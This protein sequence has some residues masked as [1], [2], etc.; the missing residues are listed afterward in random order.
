MAL[1]TQEPILFAKTIADNIAYGDNSRDIPME[2]IIDAAK[3]ANI[4]NFIATLPLVGKLS[5]ALC[6]HMVLK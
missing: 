4:H 5:G 3:A 6:V 2:E 1:V